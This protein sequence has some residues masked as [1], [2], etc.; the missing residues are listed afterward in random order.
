ML[1]TEVNTSSRSDYLVVGD[2]ISSSP[3]PGLTAAV[4]R[5]EQER[6]I[7]TMIDE[8]KSRGALLT[9][10]PVKRAKKVHTP[11]RVH[12]RLIEP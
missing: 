4:I 12:H 1:L 5:R 2:A 9:E 7:H 10:V 6:G 3:L 8:P 11:S